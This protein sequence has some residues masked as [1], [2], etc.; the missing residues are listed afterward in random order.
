MDGNIKRDLSEIYCEKWMKL[1]Q[2]RGHWRNSVGPLGSGEPWYFASVMV[3]GCRSRW[4]RDLRDEPSSLS[5]TLRSW[6]RIPLKASMSVCV[7]LFYVCVAL[8]V[9][10]GLYDRLITC[11][12]SPTDC[13]KVITNLK[14]RSGSNKGAVELLMSE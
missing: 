12:R 6:V 1:G 4:P 2:G 7:R 8:C 13:V 5:R 11:K 9:G 3:V 10:S 14:K